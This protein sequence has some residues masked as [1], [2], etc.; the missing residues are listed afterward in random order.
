M[1]RFRSLCIVGLLAGA[2]L[3]TAE[4]Q[5]ADTGRRAGPVLRVFV[6]CKFCDVEF[7]RKEIT[8]VNHVR[9]RQVAQVHVLVTTQDTG[10]GGTEYTLKFIGLQDFAGSE[11]QLRYIAA[12]TSTGDDSRKGL[13][14]VLKLG[15]VRFAARLP[16]ARNITIGYTAD[17]TESGSAKQPHDPWNNWVFRLSANGNLNGEA[18]TTS[19]FL[20]GSVSASRVTEDWK[21]RVSFSGNRNRSSYTL[22]DTTQIKSRSSSYYSDGLVARSLG[23]HWTAGF[24]ASTITSTVDNE[25]LVAQAGPAVEYDF[26]K[27]SESTRRLFTLQYGINAIHARYTDTTV[28]GTTRE[29][30]VNQHLTLS[31]NAQQPWGNANI[32]ITG[33]NYLHDFSKNRV[34][35]FGGANLRLLKGLSFNV[36]GSYSRVRDQLS[37]A[38]GSVSTEDLLLRLRQLKTGYRYFMYTGLSYTFG[39]IFNNIV[40]PRFGSSGG[41]FFFSN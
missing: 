7:F 28:F 29:S 22:D 35:V 2:A 39:S 11:D 24:L 16:N 19:S 4:S 31:F 34:E 26:F 38:K 15:L 23:P 36:F 40:N 9:D 5:P 37:L 33:S 27:Y 20:R 1:R 3:H 25:D 32:G 41:G 30:L 10:G 12:A 18:S 13:A 17:T 14:Q 6:D 8:F 21:F